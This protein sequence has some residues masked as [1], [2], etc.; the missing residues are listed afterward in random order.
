MEGRKDSQS[1]QCKAGHDPKANSTFIPYGTSSK[2]TN[3]Y[4]SPRLAGSLPLS[5]RWWGGEG[6]KKKSRELFTV[7][8][9]S[10]L[11]GELATMTI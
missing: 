11:T 6:K 10:G 5:C 3:I 4:R 9:K 1:A 7:I 8:E 2:F